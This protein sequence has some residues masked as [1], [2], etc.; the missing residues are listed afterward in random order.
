MRYKVFP[1]SC[2]SPHRCWSL[3]IRAEKDTVTSLARLATIHSGCS[4]WHCWGTAPVQGMGFIDSVTTLSDVSIC[5]FCTK[6]LA[7]TRIILYF[8]PFPYDWR[9]RRYGSWVWWSCL[10]ACRREEPA[11]CREIQD[12]GHV[13]RSKCW[14][15][16]EPWSLPFSSYTAGVCWVTKIFKCSRLFPCLVF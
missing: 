15:P 1:P 10:A 5:W 6:C 7:Q 13:P 9:I 8:T 2:V 16:V 11:L 14:L 4:W 12:L 3:S